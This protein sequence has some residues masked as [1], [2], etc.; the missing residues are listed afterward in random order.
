T[1]T[2]PLRTECCRTVSRSPSRSG[3]RSLGPSIPSRRRVDLH[4]AASSPYRVTAPDAASPIRQGE[5]LSDLHQF[6]LEVRSIGSQ[7][8]TGKPF[9]HPYALVLT[10]DCD[11]DQDFRVRFPEPQPSDK[12]IPGILFCEVVTAEEL[13]GIIRQTN[14]KLWDRIKINK[15]ERYH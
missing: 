13:F 8:A 5:I 2:R 14:K 6:R 4:P 10:Q 1:R 11:L 9:R 3:R 12:L 15:D 7:E